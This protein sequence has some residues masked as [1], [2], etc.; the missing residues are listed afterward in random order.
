M[1]KGCALRNRANI[2]VTESHRPT[3]KVFW[4]SK[5][6]SDAKRER[7]REKAR[8]IPREGWRGRG[9]QGDECRRIMKTTMGGREVGREREREIPLKLV[10]FCSRRRGEDDDDDN[11]HGSGGGG[12][13]PRLN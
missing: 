12:T 11:D 5:K 6:K 4:V 9:Y 2:Y 10:Q 3:K 13:I 8:A 1:V 7:E